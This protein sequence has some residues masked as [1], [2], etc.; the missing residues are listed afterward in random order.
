MAV[1]SK[2]ITLSYKQGEATEYTKLTN[3]LEIPEM[4]NSSSRE[5]IDVTTLDDDKKKSVPGLME[6]AESELSFNFL[7][8]KEQFQTLAAITESA[9]WQVAF[10][11]GLTA[12]FAGIPSINTDGAGV[13]AAITYTLNISIEGE[14][15]F[16]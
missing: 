7:Y 4:G 14:I 15:T 11:D 10:P 16:A 1:I 3:L 13:S 5:R 2:G 6:E 8:E 12:T 9:E